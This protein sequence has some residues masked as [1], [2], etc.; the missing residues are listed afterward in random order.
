MTMHAAGGYILSGIKTVLL[1]DIPATEAEEHSPLPK[2]VRLE[3][4]DDTMDEGPNDS[5]DSHTMD[6][7]PSGSTGFPSLNISCD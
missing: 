7:G 4:V 3:N 5:T 6:D 1:P 2:R